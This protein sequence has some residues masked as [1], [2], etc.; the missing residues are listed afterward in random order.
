MSKASLN[1]LPETEKLSTPSVINENLSATTGRRTFNTVSNS[2]QSTQSNSNLNEILKK[3]RE[4]RR[5]LLSVLRLLDPE[6]TQTIS[7]AL[8][9]SALVDSLIALEKSSKQYII[10]NLCDETGSINYKKVVHDFVIQT[11]QDFTGNLKASWHVKQAVKV[12]K[13][14]KITYLNGQPYNQDSTPSKV[15]T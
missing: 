12:Q 10:E 13:N 3:A 7:F 6:Q 1:K 9:D 14:K 11:S 8:F 2:E 5:S 15:S 4:N